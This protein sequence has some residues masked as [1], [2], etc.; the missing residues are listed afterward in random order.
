MIT[1]LA[2]ESMTVVDGKSAYMKTL[3]LK[4]SLISEYV[5]DILVVNDG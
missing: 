1:H 2:L 3:D 5:A 4:E